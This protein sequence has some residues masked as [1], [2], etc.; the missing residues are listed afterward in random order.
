M[1]QT[2]TSVIFLP[3]IDAI[4]QIPLPKLVT[5]EQSGFTGGLSVDK[6]RRLNKTYVAQ[7]ALTD[8]SE[9]P[10][11][12]VCHIQDT[13]QVAS[14]YGMIDNYVII[15]GKH[16]YHAAIKK[17]R[18][19]I[20]AHIGSYRNEEEVV[21]AYLAANI[22]HGQPANRNTRAML[23]A[24]MYE[25]DNT[26]T[27]EEISLRVGLSVPAVVKILNSVNMDIAEEDEGPENESPNQKEVR[28]L[29]NAIQRFYF[30]QQDILKRFIDIVDHEDDIL[31]VVNELLEYN[32]TL[33]P[34][35][36]TK[37]YESLKV[38]GEL[39]TLLKFGR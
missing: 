3:G 27:P 32:G 31:A 12:E 33:T 25:M 36:S 16:R 1:T 9:W 11:I 21:I 30:H 20:A 7:L 4:Q 28:F 5:I 23:A 15:D 8:D 14:N 17:K 37:L 13:S 6:L 39:F 2:D 29:C 22:K 38:L 35:R 34:R 24:A 19:D 26:L 10:P 18:I